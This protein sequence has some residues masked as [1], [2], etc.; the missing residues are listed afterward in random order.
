MAGTP[1][2]VREVIDAGPEEAEGPRSLIAPQREIH[3][4][5]R[6]W[7][8]VIVRLGPLARNPNA[9]LRDHGIPVNRHNI[10]Y[11]IVFILLGDSLRDARSVRRCFGAGRISSERSPLHA[12]SKQSPGSCAPR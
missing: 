4:D 10:V 5:H 3:I 11:A 8:L 1:D 2:T 6:P 7:E 12:R 9:Y